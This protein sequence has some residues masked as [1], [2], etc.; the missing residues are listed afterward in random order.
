MGVQYFP[1]DPSL[2]SSLG[3]ALGQGLGVRFQQGQMQNQQS[4]LAN[5]LFGGQANQFSGIPME[6]QLKVAEYLQ[7]Q[8][9]LQQSS[10]NQLNLAKQLFPENPEQ[11]ASL[12]PQ[13]QI[14]LAKYFKQ[15]QDAE[16][17][18]NLINT[19][20]N[21]GMS[22]EGQETKESNMLTDAQIASVASVDPNLAKI[23]Q[24]QK[25]TA[26][27][28]ARSTKKEQKEEEEKKRPIET[29]QK[30]FNSMAK[31]LKRGKI[32]MGS[33]LISTALGGQT[34][35]DTAE[36][37]TATGGLEALLVDMVSRGTLSNARFKYITET[38]LPKPGDRQK[39]I[40]GKMTA[41]ADLLGL[42][43]SELTNI[44][45]KSSVGKKS[46]KPSLEDIWK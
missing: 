36:F 29:A 13:Q 42:D 31:I 1:A 23:L 5:A 14:A 19:L 24:M 41:L 16:F 34:A 3:Q 6:Q 7:N 45:K 25:D 28:E 44:D 38:L 15:N 37:T 8:Q 12:P 46:E 35:K 40:E 4:Q 30:S 11:F 22:P 17:K 2:A 18:Q 33:G 21:N 27:K 43:S 32:G 9:K 20:F 10:G 26:L 39:E